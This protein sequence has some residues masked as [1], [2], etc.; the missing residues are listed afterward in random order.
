MKFP[1][2][3]E[4]DKTVFQ[5]GQSSRKNL[6]IHHR[7]LNACTGIRYGIRPFLQK[8]EQVHTLNFPVKIIERIRYY[9]DMQTSLHTGRY[10]PE[11]HR[12]FHHIVYW[13]NAGVPPNRELSTCSENGV[14]SQSENELPNSGKHIPGP[15]FCHFTEN[16]QKHKS[17][18]DFY[19]LAPPYFLYFGNDRLYLRYK[20]LRNRMKNTSI[21]QKN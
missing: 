18:T 10:S 8:S 17:S 7:K 1:S 12:V 4:P 3:P 20:I 11:K 15:A 13:I 6:L 14:S 21:R 2:F 19:T 16:L 5:N 9:R